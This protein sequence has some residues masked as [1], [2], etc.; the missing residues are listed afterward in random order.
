MLWV[1][2]GIIIGVFL[3]GLALLLIWRL[4]TYIHDRRE[5]QNFEKERANA[6]WEGGENPIYKPSTSVFKNPT[7][8]IK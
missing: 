7:Y 1:I 3:V 2:L 8:N 5:F 6:T 4:L